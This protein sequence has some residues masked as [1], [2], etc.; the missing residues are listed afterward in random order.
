M[1][2]GQVLISLDSDVHGQEPDETIHVDL[3]SDIV[4]ALYKEDL[5][6]K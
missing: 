6:S 3:A 2:W 5:L 1:C 4:K